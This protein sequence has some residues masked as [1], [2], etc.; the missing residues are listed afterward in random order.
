[1][2]LF[3]ALIL[4]IVE[5]LTEFLPI[6]STFH[7]IFAS[8]LLGIP[9]TE[10]LKMF[11]VFIQSGAILSVVFLYGWETFKDR[12]LWPK[13]VASFIPTAVI[14]FGLHEIIKSVFF[15]T[16]SLMIMMFIGL[17]IGFMAYEWWL[18]KEDKQPAG[19]VATLTYSQAIMV[20]L[21]QAVAVI[22]GVSRAGAVIVAMMLLGI[23]RDEAAKYSFI[24]AVP[25]ICGAAFL[26]IV[27][28]RSELM[29][30]GDSIMLLMAGF[31]A[32]FFSALI[33][34]KWFISYLQRHTLTQFGAY[35]VV[36]GMILAFL[37]Y[38]AGI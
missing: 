17:G 25:T 34:L 37:L 28:M 2:T 9:E 36:A 3:H 22:P 10:F 5:G 1:M 12:A 18:A 13:V 27:K 31:V 30:A 14:G 24:L 29:A 6:S 23:R 20:G 26:D 38:T 8:K 21:A 16:E 33:V 15:E 11:E 4:G 35:R 19:A 7:L 32:A